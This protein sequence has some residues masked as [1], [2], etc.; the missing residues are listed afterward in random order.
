MGTIPMKE[1]VGQEIYTRD[2]GTVKV[3]KNS[4]QDGR[5]H[6]VLCPNGAYQHIN[7]LPISN[8]AEIHEAFGVDEVI[9]GKALYEGRVS[10]AEARKA[11]AEGEATR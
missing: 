10:L 4:W 7:G 8:E 9:V 6:I 11:L 1:D 3:D 5:Y 2:H